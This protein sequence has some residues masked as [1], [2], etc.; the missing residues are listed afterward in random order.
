MK[1]IY[2]T[3]IY[4]I[5][6]FSL[7]AQ[8]ADSISTTTKNFFTEV[9]KYYKEYK[10]NKNVNENYSKM[11]VVKLV[12]KFYK[13]KAEDPIGFRN[14]I[15]YLAKIREEK[16]HESK[17]IETKPGWKVHLFKQLISEKMGKNFVEIIE[18]PFYLRIKV[19]SLNQAFYNSKIDTLIVAPKTV[20]KAE[21]QEIIKGEKFFKKSRIIEINIINQ[22]MAGSEKFFEVNKE[23]FVPL[24]PWECY[25]NECESIRLSFLSDKNYGIYPI[26]NEIIKTD[27]DFFGYG[28]TNDW[29]N[30]KKSFLSKYIIK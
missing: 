14:Y 19:L 2:L 1:I 23:Y 30:F 22:W 27:Y 18:V 12:K 29:S 4:G 20:I 21:I 17:S 6:T 13:A 11:D 8:T 28:N 25:G 16:F 10:A 15:R 3:I 7:L 26:V 24:E 9:E 5:L